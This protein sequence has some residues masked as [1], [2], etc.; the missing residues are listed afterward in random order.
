MADYF[1]APLRHNQTNV[2]QRLVK[3]QLDER[4]RTEV[5]EKNRL[6]STLTLAHHSSSSN[7]KIAGIGVVF[8]SI[9]QIKQRRATPS[10]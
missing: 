2:R 1:N 4:V 9:S 8:C 3:Y 10:L 7:S 5:N 6:T